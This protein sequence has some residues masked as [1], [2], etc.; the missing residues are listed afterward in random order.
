[1][2]ML[3][4]KALNASYEGRSCRKGKD[5]LWSFSW[6]LQEYATTVTFIVESYF[7]LSKIKIKSCLQFNYVYYHM[8]LFNF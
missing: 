3:R 6:G 7:G 4:E 1:M 2:E 8:H 5:C